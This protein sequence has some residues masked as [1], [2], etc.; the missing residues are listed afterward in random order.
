VC[1]TEANVPERDDLL[2]WAESSAVI[3]ANSVLGARSNRN[4]IMVDVCM[5]VTGLAPEFG[6]FFPEN[7]RGQVLVRLDIEK[8][9]DDAL[10][11][12]IG[13]RVVDRIPVLTHWPFDTVQLKNMGAAMAAAGAIAMFHVEG[14]TPECPSLDAVFDDEPDETITITQADLDG[15]RAERPVQDRAGLVVFGCPQMTLA[16]VEQVG[17]HFVG[18]RVRK[19]TL[20][21]VMPG[22]FEKLQQMPLFDELLKAG[23]E[24][25]QHCPLAGLTVRLSPR[26]KHV[27]TCSGKLHYYLQG[28]DYG[29]LEDLLEQAGVA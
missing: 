13:K 18:K 8:M 15:L 23:V 19:R 9:D 24:F 14:V 29:T 17:R 27:L 11:Y 12:L 6:L 3:Y 20:F 16:E 4:S 5:A 10:G 21:H 2:G 1:Y 28:A 25:H 22:D 26:Q 7:R